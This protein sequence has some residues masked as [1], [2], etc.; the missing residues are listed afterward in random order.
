MH[1]DALQNRCYNDANRA[2]ATGGN[3]LAA[4]QSG[5]TRSL[6]CGFASSDECAGSAAAVPCLSRASEME[7][8]DPKGEFALAGDEE[9]WVATHQDP[10][11]DTAAAAAAEQDILD[12]DDPEPAASNQGVRADD[13]EVPDISEL[14]LVEPDD[15]VCG[16]ECQ[17]TVG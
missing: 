5:L 15:E 12:L 9:G 2:K 4:M 16:A 3:V 13:D 8:Y 11:A 7:K 6:Q 10:K 14:E 1:V 17:T